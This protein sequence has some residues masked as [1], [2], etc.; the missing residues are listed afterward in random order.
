VISDFDFT[1]SRFSDPDGERCES[2]HS[3]FGVATEMTNPELWTD[4]KA[5]KDKYIQIE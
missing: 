3:V 5:L 2:M 4:I 1:L